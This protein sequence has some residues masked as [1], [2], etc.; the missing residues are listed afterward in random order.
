MMTAFPMLAAAA[1]Y[2]RGRHEH[3]AEV[4]KIA[5]QIK[6]RSQVSAPDD[7]NELRRQMM[8]IASLADAIMEIR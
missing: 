2:D 1:V 5:E 3:A 7:V 4:R 8:H 6:A